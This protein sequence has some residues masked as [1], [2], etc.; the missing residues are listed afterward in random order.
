MQTI[1]ITIISPNPP[2]IVV[3]EKLPQKTDVV[4]KLSDLFKQ[5]QISQKVNKGETRVKSLKDETEVSITEKR[6]VAR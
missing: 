4:E 5:F 2:N 3:E 1:R 6:E